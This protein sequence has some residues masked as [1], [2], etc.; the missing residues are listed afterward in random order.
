MLSFPGMRVNLPWLIKLLWRGFTSEVFFFL[1]F[2]FSFPFLFFS[3]FFLYFFFLRHDF[4]QIRK[5][6]RK[7]LPHLL[8]PKCF[9]LKI[10][11]M[12]APTPNHPPFVSS[13]AEESPST[14]IN[15]SLRELITLKPALQEV[16]KSP[17]G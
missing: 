10:N 3:L 1:F 5:G 11:H 17:S 4:R 14:H 12:P 16:I 2:P 8:I 13:K 7:S 9:W 6:Q 15:K